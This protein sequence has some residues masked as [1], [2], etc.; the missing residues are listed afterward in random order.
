MDA[1]AHFVDPD[2]RRLLEGHPAPRAALFLDRDGIV[3]ADHGYVHTEARTD[4]IPGIF[5][6][7]AAAWAAGRLPIVVTNQAGIARGYYNEAAF[8]DYTRWVHATFAAPEIDRDA[9][10]FPAGL[11]SAREPNVGLT[12][13]ATG[14]ILEITTTRFAQS[15]TI[16]APGYIPEDDGFHMAPGQTRRVRL[17]KIDEKPLRGHVSALN[18]DAT[19]RI[20]VIA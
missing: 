4:W 7:V 14:D 19:A 3:N 18:S 12:A 15:V 8:L 17:Q 11:P 9:F 10:Y 20:E 16:E 5:D 13:K 1:V 6:I 2:A